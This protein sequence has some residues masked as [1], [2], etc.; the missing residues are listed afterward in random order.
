VTSRAL[1]L[2]AAVSGG[3]MLQWYTPATPDA[4]R[5]NLENRGRCST[6]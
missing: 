2:G 1:F 4:M 3:V 6:A 5:L